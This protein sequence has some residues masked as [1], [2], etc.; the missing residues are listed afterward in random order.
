MDQRLQQIAEN[1]ERYKLG[2][3]DKFHFKCRGCGT[4]CKHRDDIMLTTRDLYNIARKLGMT[5]DAV[6]E[7]YCEAYVGST[8]RIPIVRLRPVGA[9][10]R[11][12]LLSD[13]RC[14]VHEAKP[15]VCALYPLG[16]IF[17]PN[18]DAAKELSGESGV[19]YIIQPVE[20][21][22]RN[23]SNSIESWLTKFG[24]PLHDEFYVQWNETV[25]FAAEFFR[26]LEADNA[27]ANALDALR[28]MTFGALY[29]AY[30]TGVALWPQFQNNATNLKKLL[31]AVEK[32]ERFAG[33]ENDAC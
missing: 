19:I 33:G 18:K 23:R 11:C 26:R 8:S 1:I 12:P 2:L 32:G 31:G 15:A 21:G 27:P 25:M 17:V 24:L 6:I 9:D 5:L 7:K 13:K 16:R 4:C 30:D 22:S 10:G 20:C 3:N 14:L 28:A 29:V